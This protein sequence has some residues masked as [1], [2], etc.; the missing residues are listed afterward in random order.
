MTNTRKLFT[1]IKED[2]NK[3]TASVQQHPEYVHAAA[4]LIDMK[5]AEFNSVIDDLEKA[6]GV[7]KSLTV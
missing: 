7:N 1:F 5:M 4:T 2:Y 6:E 3:F